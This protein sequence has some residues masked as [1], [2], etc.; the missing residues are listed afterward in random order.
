VGDLA[1]ISRRTL[2]RTLGD[3]AG[4]HLYELARGRDDR[5]VVCDEPPKSVGSEETFEADLDAPPEILREVLRLSD[6]TASRLRSKGTCGRTVTLK[7]RFSNFK[8]ITRSLTLAEEV[9]T[10]AEIYEIA[11]SL[12][13]RLD[14]DRPRIRLLGVSV[15]GLVPGP[16]RRQIPLLDDEGKPSWREATR[17]ID[18]IRARFGSDAVTQAVLLE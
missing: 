2:E 7:I 9:D 3:A 14:P 4:A 17:A 6:R 12:Y 18:A 13:E 1:R 10:A 15:S 8:T 16:P 11:R 5:P